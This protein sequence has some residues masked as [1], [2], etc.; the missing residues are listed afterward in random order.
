METKSKGESDIAT[1][2]GGCMCGAVRYE[3]T[4]EPTVMLNC[5]CRDCQRVSGGAYV[6]AMVLARTALK[7]T[8]EVKYYDSKADTL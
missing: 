2:T 4:G 5:H 3:W 6:T 8:G 1:A 7:I